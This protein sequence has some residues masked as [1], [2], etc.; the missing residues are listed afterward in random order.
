MG[1]AVDAC[2]PGAP[3]Q[4]V[5][6]PLR[7]LSHAWSNCLGLRNRRDAARR[8]MDCIGFCSM[9]H[10]LQ[11]ALRQRIHCSTDKSVPTDVGKQG[12]TVHVVKGT[13]C[14]ATT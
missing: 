13:A 6:Q 11:V 14:L 10:A 3:Q 2:P 8:A 9:S 5:L 1:S 12:T 7:Q 4:S